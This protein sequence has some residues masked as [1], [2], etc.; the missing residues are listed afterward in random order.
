MISN[1]ISKILN[2]FLGSV[3]IVLGFVVI[4][5]STRTILPGYTFE[6]IAAFEVWGF[7]QLM[8]GFWMKSAD[9]P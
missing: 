9:P 5:L 4:F 2:L 8:H 1:K 7:L 6:I 3:I